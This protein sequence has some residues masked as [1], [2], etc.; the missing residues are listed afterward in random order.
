MATVTL[1]NREQKLFRA[2]LLLSIFTVLYNLAEGTIATYFGA[3]EET[4]S[5]FGF[6]VDS[7]IEV[8]SGLGVLQMVLRIQY[9]P[10]TQRSKAEVLALRITGAAFYLLALGLVIGTAIQIWSG[11]RPAP[12]LVG[13][14]IACISIAIM[15]ALLR[16][17]L[18]VGRALNSAPIIADANCTRAC[19][20]MSVVLLI[21]SMLYRF[22]GVALIDGLGALGIAWFCFKE[23]REAFEKAQGKACSCECG[24]HCETEI[25]PAQN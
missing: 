11:A 24:D 15:W 10:D 13:T 17:K 23:G 1:S 5:L 3:Q 6:G 14:I 9:Q 16:G 25:A 12:S 19:I 4:L 22:S 7:F 20:Y 18:L 21:S 2:A 8:I